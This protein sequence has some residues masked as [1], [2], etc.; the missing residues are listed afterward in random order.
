MKLTAF[1][2]QKLRARYLLSLGF[3]I[4]TFYSIYQEITEGKSWL[5]I[6][7]QGKCKGCVYQW[8]CPSPSVFER[9][10]GRCDLCH[11]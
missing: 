7:D 3:F 11:T 2:E 10:M 4:F 8:L 1:K 5:N 9:G 6:R